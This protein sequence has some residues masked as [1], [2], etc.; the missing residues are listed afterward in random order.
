MREA[1][2]TVI[3]GGRFAVS[4]YRTRAARPHIVLE[5]FL[6]ANESPFTS[7]AAS[8]NPADAFRPTEGNPSRPSAFNNLTN[9]S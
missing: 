4:Y 8:A 6:S 7:E 2:E 1:F 9:N 3:V 5:R